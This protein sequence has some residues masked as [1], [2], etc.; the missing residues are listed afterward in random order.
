MH[1]EEPSV[2]SKGLCSQCHC[3]HKLSVAARLTS[4]TARSLHTMRAIHHHRRCNLQHV[5]YIPE[6]HNQVVISKHVSSLREPHVLS[7]RLA[8]LLHGVTHVVAAEELCLF[9][10]HRLSRLGGSHEQVRLSAQERRNLY[11]IHHLAHRSCLIALVDVGKQSQSIL[12]LYVG[13]HLQSL[14]HSRTSE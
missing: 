2:G 1:L 10:V 14:V 8:S 11:H 4:G 7:S 5:R 12:A 13:K 9:D 6:I 3:R